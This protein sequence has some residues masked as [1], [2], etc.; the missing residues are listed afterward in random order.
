MDAFSR[1]QFSLVREHFSA[2][3]KAS[4]TEDDLKHGWDEIVLAS[5]GFQSQLS[6]TFRTV[7][8]AHVYLAKSQFDNFKVELGLAFGNA[9]QITDVFMF[10]VANVSAEMMETSAKA[11]VELLRRGQFD[12]LSA[13][14]TDHMKD[15]FPPERL[16]ANWV[17]IL[18][19]LGELKNIKQAGKDPDMDQ[20]N[21]RCLFENGDANIGIVFDLL[22]RISELWVSPV[23]L[24]A[25][26]Y[27]Q[28]SLGGEAGELELTVHDSGIGFDPLE[29]MKGRG[30]GFTSIS[31][32][33]KLVNEN[34]SIDSQPQHRTTIQVRVPLI[35]RKAQDSS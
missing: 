30:L 10:L 33:L 18:T 25:P 26:R 14:L 20:V 6:Q 4:L 19:R 29:A 8:G 31:E 32:R 34:L 1:E 27:T 17:H 22:G 2:D 12:L 28:V 24:A 15:L 16:A 11:V 9:N 35:T 3:L 5:G 13:R 23:E 7:R 21:V